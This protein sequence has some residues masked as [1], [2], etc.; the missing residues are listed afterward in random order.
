M[1]MIDILVAQLLLKPVRCNF[2]NDVKPL[3]GDVG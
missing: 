1:S 2:L 3:S